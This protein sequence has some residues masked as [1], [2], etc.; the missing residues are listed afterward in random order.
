MCGRATPDADPASPFLRGV[1]A[2]F[3][4][5]QRPLKYRLK[6]LSLEILNEPGSEECL[7]ISAETL[8]ARSSRLTLAVYSTGFVSVTASRPGPSRMGGWALNLAWTGEAG[9][10]PPVRLRAAFE[11]SLDLLP[12]EAREDDVAAE[13]AKCW[14]SVTSNRAAV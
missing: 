13:F 9:Q 14:S 7:T 11:A 4:A 12:A 6:S 3:R 8:A 2:A 10:A 5:R 1:L